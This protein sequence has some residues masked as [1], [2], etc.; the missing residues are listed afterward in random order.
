MTY[1]SDYY[2]IRLYDEDS[3]FVTILQG[4]SSLE[5]WQRLN[6]PWNHQIRFDL[7]WDDPQLDTL[8]AIGPDWF[9]LIYRTNPLTL[10]KELVWEGIHQTTVDQ[11]RAD[12]TMII[13]LYGQGYTSWLGRRVIIPPSTDWE[14]HEVTGFAGNAIKEYVGYNMILGSAPD[15][16]RVMPGLA[17]EALHNDGDTITYSA[18]YTNLLTA[19]QTIAEDGNVKF[20]ILGT[21]DPPT[22]FYIATREIWGLDRRVNSSNP[23]RGDPMLFDFIKKNMDIPILSKNY[24]E[25]RTVVYVAGTG[26]GIK[27]KTLELTNLTALAESPRARREAYTDS[28]GAESNDEM[29]TVGVAYLEENAAKNSLTFNLR[30]NESTRWMRDFNLGDI[31]TAHYFDHLSSKEISEVHVT[32]NTS[33]DTTFIERIDIELND[34]T[35]GQIDYLAEWT[36]E[37]DDPYDFWPVIGPD[38]LFSGIG[39]LATFDDN[40]YV[41]RTATF[42]TPIPVW[43]SVDLSVSGT[44]QQFVVDPFCSYYLTGTG[45]VDGWLVTSTNIYKVT[46]IFGTPVAVSQKTF[47]TPGGTVA[48]HSADASFGNEGHAVVVSYYGSDGTYVTYTTDGSAWSAETQL[49][50]FYQTDSDISEEAFPGCYVSPKTAGLVYTT[51]YSSNNNCVGYVST[52]YGSTWTEA[53]G[54][55]APQIIPDQGMANDIHVPYNHVDELKAYHGV[56]QSDVDYVTG[57]WYLGNTLDSQALADCPSSWCVA[58]LCE[59][60]FSDAYM[61]AIFIEGAVRFGDTIKRM[62]PDSVEG[63]GNQ[64]PGYDH[65]FTYDSSDHLEDS[66][67]VSGNGIFLIGSTAVGNLLFGAGNFTALTGQEN[68]RWSQNIAAPVAAAGE[69]LTA[70]LDS[71]YLQTGT[72]SFKI[73]YNIN[74]PDS[75]YAGGVGGNSIYKTDGAVSEDISPDDGS[76]TY[77][78]N[79]FGSRWRIMTCPIDETVL[80]AVASREGDTGARAFVS[81]DD[82]A[83]WNALTLDNSDVRRGAVSGDDA[84]TFFLWGANA[85]IQYSE[86]SGTTLNDKSGNLGGLGAGELIGICG[87]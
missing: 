54:T 22:T 42:D 87:G 83:S 32:V 68:V 69:S 86:D 57:G 74:S 84:A 12:G 65:T 59:D 40:G 43:D 82:G 55:N 36:I 35:D 26:V 80:L 38:S 64:C 18:R 50:A 13:T 53:N 3:T 85:Y 52:N 2:E 27:R 73:V 81:N 71:H 14:V 51:A 49:T 56:R 30:Q 29:I 63:I 58:Q 61:C 33:R 25:Q 9:Y 41:Y 1:P 16:D 6:A 72:V 15:A 62:G 5:Y 23:D 44:P 21:D 70:R 67:N 37:Y 78:P 66:L 46:D 28:R 10:D 4:W 39:T 19:C 48:N 8:R 77:G 24:S 45:T 20:G 79:D 7:A 76:N 17:V 34:L 75:P 47:R 31:V 60:S 11:A